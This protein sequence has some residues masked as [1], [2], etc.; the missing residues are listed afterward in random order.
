MPLVAGV[1]SSTQST[2][3]VVHDLETGTLLGRSSAPHPH[4]VPPVAEHDPRA[5]WDAFGTAW[6]ESLAEGPVQ[7]RDVVGLSVAAQQH[8]LVVLDHEGA[9][10]RPAKL[11]LDTESVPDADWLV[12]HLPGGAAAWARACGSVPLAAFTIS[13]LSWLHRTEPEVF[14]RIAKIALPHDWL[15][16]RLTGRFVTDRGDASGT[17]Y[18]SPHDGE[19]RYDL[20]RIVDARDWSAALPHVVEPFEPIGSWG[21]VVV[22]PGTGDNMAAALA[23]GVQPGDVLISVGT[24]G[25]VCTVSETAT[26]D[27][28]GAVAGFASADGKFLPLVCTS[29]AT[30][31]FDLAAAM[32]GVGLA[33]LDRLAVTARAGAG[34]LT[35]L[36]YLDGERTPNLPASR[37]VLDGLRSTTERADLARAA[38]EGVACSLLDALDFLG[39]VAPV[40]GR[41]LLV[42]GGSASVT[43]RQVLSDLSGRPVEVPRFEDAVARGA[44]IQAACVVSGRSPIEVV[45]SW[46]IERS[47][48]VEPACESDQAAEIRNA[49]ARVRRQAEDARAP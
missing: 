5:W 21:D 15:N 24:S 23:L 28:S 16:L 22:G 9:V 43:L 18:W 42:G 29:N 11:W 3:V 2:K 19:Y 8:G 12:R 7:G 45:E 33:E 44:A 41:V 14:A 40:D 4:V 1:D 30:R 48:S 13:K 25:T 36:P 34:G 38:F 37:G 39:R 6:S 35:F 10:L 49:Y 20:L 26:N 47:A 17:G 31:V 32:L 27:E 46:Q